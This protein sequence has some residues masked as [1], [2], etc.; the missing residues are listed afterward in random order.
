M[1]NTQQFYGRL[2][3]TIQEEHEPLQLAQL[4]ASSEKLRIGLDNHI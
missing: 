4:L 1:V 3:F 2:P